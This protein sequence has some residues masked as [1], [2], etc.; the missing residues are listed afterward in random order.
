M[1]VFVCLASVY[2]ST[3]QEKQDNTM[4]LVNIEF[5]YTVNPDVT[6]FQVYNHTDYEDGSTYE[7]YVDLKF[8][9]YN[10]EIWNLSTADDWDNFTDYVEK[11]YENMSYETINGIKVYNTTAGQGEHAGE[12]RY[13]AC[14][15]DSTHKTIV[16]FC[17]PYQ[18][19]TVKMASTLK[20][21]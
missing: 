8:T 20:F 14:I 7:H 11:G 9:G 18:N 19:E 10:I 16:Q 17:T 3:P 4:R 13:E 21:H 2:S 1:A 15:M 12:P 6:Q 5:N